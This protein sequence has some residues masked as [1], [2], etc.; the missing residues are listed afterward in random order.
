MLVL[1]KLMFREFRLH[2]DCV[3]DSQYSR[4]FYY[5]RNARI[6]T[7]GFASVNSFNRKALR[8]M[9]RPFGANRVNISEE[10]LNSM[11]K[12]LTEDVLLCI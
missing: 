5:I 2:V 8:R 4:K 10:V 9:D 1:S 7:N 3:P 12:Q 11:Q 6:C